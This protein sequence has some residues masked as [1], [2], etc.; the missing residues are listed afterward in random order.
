MKVRASAGSDSFRRQ[1]TLQ[2]HLEK[3]QQRV[4]ELREQGDDANVG[5]RQKKAR[6]RAARE[7]EER[8]RAALTNHKKIAASRE[9]RKKGD[10]ATA[11]AST[12]DPEAR[13]MQMPDGGFRPAYN[14]Q[15]ATDTASGIIVGVDV[16]NQGN[17]QGQIHPMIEQIQKRVERVPDNILADGSYATVK[18]IDKTA[19]MGTITYAPPKEVAQQKAKGKNP[20]EAKKGDPPA[21]AEWRVRMGTEA[22]KQL[23]RLRGQT[24]EWVN[25]CM[26]NRGLY[27]VRVRGLTKVKAVLLWMVLGHNLLRAAALRAQ[28][29][30]TGKL[31]T[32]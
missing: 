31:T 4:R 25:A 29:A 18:D 26:R 16:T 8:L 10:G 32:P 3:A 15:F 5:P 17:D 12:T 11:R 13:K 19:Q 1:P 30:E 24:A 27:Q 14:T 20:Y 22:A 7:R 9:A 28:R 23:Y 21:V 2:E 6:E